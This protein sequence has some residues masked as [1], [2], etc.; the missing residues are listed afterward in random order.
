MLAP[1]RGG[2]GW[3]KT[4]PFWLPPRLR[5][6]HSRTRPAMRAIPTIEP[7][8]IPAM[9]PP[10]SFLDPSEALA[11]GAVVDVDGVDD[12]P[13]DEDGRVIDFVI[14]GRTTPAHTDSA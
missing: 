8:T 14:V 2:L 7:M 5:L 12:D 4:L 13:R 9:E 6:R 3:L 11:G 1:L 10:E